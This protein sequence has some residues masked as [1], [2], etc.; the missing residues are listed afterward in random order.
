MP[1]HPHEIVTP[2]PTFPYVGVDF[3]WK[4]QIKQRKKYSR[5]F[6]VIFA[7]MASRAVHLELMDDLS[8]EQF[9]LALLR[10]V[11]KRGKP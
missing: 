2:S 10:F 5:C 9:L 4:F 1:Q 6:A 8:T 11:A 7:C 3:F